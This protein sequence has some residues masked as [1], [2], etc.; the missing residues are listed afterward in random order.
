VQHNTVSNL[1]PNIPPR[2]GATV[3][4][5]QPHGGAG[6]AAVPTSV[7]PAAPFRQAAERMPSTCCRIPLQEIKFDRND[8]AV[9][10]ELGRGSFGTVYA[11]RWEKK[12]VAVKKTVLQLHPT[13]VDRLWREL[14][15]QVQA[16]H[17]HVVR[18]YGATLQWSFAKPDEVSCFIVMER[19]VTDFHT[20]LHTRPREHSPEKRV[21]DLLATPA[22]RLR[23]LMEC[24]Y[25]LRFLHSLGIV[26]ADL[27]PCNVMLNRNGT[28]QLVD[29]GWAVQRAHDASA[30]VASHKLMRGTA[31]YMDPA[32]AAVNGSSSKPASDVFS[33]GVM[34]WEV[35]TG[36]MP[37][38]S[39]SASDKKAMAEGPDAVAVLQ[40]LVST[41]FSERKFDGNSPRDILASIHERTPSL[42]D[43]IVRCWSAEQAARPAVDDIIAALEPL[44]G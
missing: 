36:R 11:G 44:V 16:S 25:S 7:S 2:E 27:K 42:V 8:E 3:A 38:E 29:F 33:W 18:V 34:A 35:L 22:A 12:R 26:H 1:L 21:Q 28:A 14:E 32:L 23:V 9:Q 30:T 31:V 40:R 41:G 4:A 10:V 15:L 37:S 17:K 20:V 6:S 39:I 19:M 43:L 5:P 24:A 13:Q